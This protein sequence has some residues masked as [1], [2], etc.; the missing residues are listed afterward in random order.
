MCHSVTQKEP[1]CHHILT[2]GSGAGFT[3]GRGGIGGNTYADSGAGVA[4]GKDGV[5]GKMYAGTVRTA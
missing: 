2:C 1:T 4:L 5:G 3:F